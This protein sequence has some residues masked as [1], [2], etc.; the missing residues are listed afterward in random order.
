M[1]LETI[2]FHLHIP[3][4]P[5]LPFGGSSHHQQGLLS[6][7]EVRPNPLSISH[8]ERTP[9]F[10]TEKANHIILAGSSTSLVLKK[11]LF[12][13][14]LQLWFGIDFIQCTSR[15]LVMVIYLSSFHFN[16]F[17]LGC[18]NPNRSIVSS[19]SHD[20]L[21]KNKILKVGGQ[22]IPAVIPMLL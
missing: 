1:S 17:N 12:Y 8:L 21:M 15:S 5:F 9:F 3:T 16:I 2:S 19:K 6:L 11:F 14:G 22:R 4:C 7:G 10:C 13:F 18:W 20:Y